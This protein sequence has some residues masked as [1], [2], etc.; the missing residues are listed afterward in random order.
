MSATTIQIP[1]DHIDAIRQSLIARRDHAERPGEIDGLLEQLADDA[2][3]SPRAYELSGP[4]PLLWSAVY[5]SLCAAAEQLAD[6]CNEF[7]RGQIA[8]DD[9]RAAIARVGSRFELLAGLGPPPGS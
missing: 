5:D 8:P 1:T 9:A 4:L 6:D 7:W 2:G 3:E